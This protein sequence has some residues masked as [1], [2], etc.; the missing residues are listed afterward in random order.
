M[1]KTLRYTVVIETA[2]PGSNLSAFVPDL[3]GCIAT[4]ISIPDIKRNLLEAIQLHLHG[5]LGDEE[6]IPSPAVAATRE[7]VLE[8]DPELAEIGSSEWIVDTVDVPSDPSRWQEGVVD[9]ALRRKP[10][11]IRASSRR[12]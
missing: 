6:R 2:P 9:I 12:I 3:P 5:L 11:A 8:S 1:A 10:A 4:G 7:D